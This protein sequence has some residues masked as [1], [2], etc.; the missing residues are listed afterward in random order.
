MLRTALRRSLPPRR[1]LSLPVN[2]RTYATPAGSTHALVFLEHHDGAL[3]A[4][5]LSALTAARQLGGKVTAL[6][7]GGEGTESVVEKAKK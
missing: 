2:A 4:S 6:V 7:V 5:S 1:F 3:D